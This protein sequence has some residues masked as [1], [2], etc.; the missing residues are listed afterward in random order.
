MVCTQYI[1]ATVYNIQV[2]SRPRNRTAKFKRQLEA[3]LK[4]DAC[5]GSKFLGE[6]SQSSPSGT[7]LGNGSFSCLRDLVESSKFDIDTSCCYKCRAGTSS[8]TTFLSNMAVTA[9]LPVASSGRKVDLL[10]PGNVHK[11][12]KALFCKD[13]KSHRTDAN[14]APRHRILAKNFCGIAYSLWSS[15]PFGYRT[16]FLCL[17]LATFCCLAML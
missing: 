15:S 3:V 17:W 6:I 12:Y 9:V 5:L 14:A 7:P 2:K 11:R 8:G 16:A 4:L 13:S 1:G 10:S